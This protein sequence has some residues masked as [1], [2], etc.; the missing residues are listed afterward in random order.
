MGVVQPLLPPPEPV[1]LCGECE[2][3]LVG[4]AGVFCR[5]F[6]EQVWDEREAQECPAY[7][8]LRN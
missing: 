1:R 7:D 4:S 5:V 2:N 6:G 3:S 8:R